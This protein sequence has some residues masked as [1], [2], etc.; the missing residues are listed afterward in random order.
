MKKILNLS[1]LLF[2]ICAFYWAC[3]KDQTA[4]ANKNLP[5]EE[6]QL[7]ANAKTYFENNVQYTNSGKSLAELTNEEKQNLNIVKSLTKN[8]VWDKAY[9]Q[10]LSIGEVVVA[11]ITFADNLF[12][13]PAGTDNATR[14]S[15]NKLMKLIVYTDSAK[16]MHAEVIT[17]QPNENFINNSTKEFSGIAVVQDWS[18][19]LLSKYQYQKGNAINITS[20]QTS[21][22]R[23]AVP[24]M[25]M[26]E[27]IH[28]CTPTY[29]Y[30]D[31]IGGPNMIYIG[32][33]GTGGG[34]SGN[35]NSG[36]SPN[37]SDYGNVAGG[38]GSGNSSRPI[39]NVTVDNVVTNLTNPCLVSVY[40]K[41]TQP[42]VTT[43]INQLFNK[44]FISYG[45]DLNVEFDEDNTLTYP[46]GQPQL[47]QSV[48][49]F[50]TNTWVIKIN[51]TFVNTSSQEFIGAGMIHEMVHSFIALY[52]EYNPANGSFTDPS[53]HT[54]M[55]NSWINN[56]KQLLINSFGINAADA[57]AI[58]LE[59]ISDVLVDDN[60]TPLPAIN[61][62]LQT[63]YNTTVEAA[64]AIASQYEEGT[65]GTKCP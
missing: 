44:A 35:S 26:A 5:T 28:T 46:N 48:E 58:C 2:I 25:L 38:G 64:H 10:K 65:K 36:G 21:A 18:G 37:G 14:L 42:G 20:P 57:T 23:I 11:P 32:C 8:V 17:A 54:V 51:P 7:I 27:P 53:T 33:E 15:I 31:G 19:N 16:Q 61:T 4:A 50:S 60:L 34:N 55:L 30:T 39:A 29:G 40:N 13:Q 56:M 12:I 47:S 52:Q 41:I 59:D 49:R 9:T 63:N 45:K 62:F 43:F 22:N 3:K 24:D 1:V 6:Q